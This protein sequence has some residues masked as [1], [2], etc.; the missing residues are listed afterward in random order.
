MALNSLKMVWTEYPDLDFSFLQEKYKAELN[1]W[2]KETQSH[3]DVVVVDVA[4]TGE[5]G[6]TVR[7]PKEEVR[8][9]L[10]EGVLNTEVAEETA[11]TTIE[12]IAVD[13]ED[14]G[15]RTGTH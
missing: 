9:D 1:E 8:L 10:S 3:Q 4:L 14:Q 13:Q 6:A 7:A 5:E 11:K 15:D 2:W 12:E